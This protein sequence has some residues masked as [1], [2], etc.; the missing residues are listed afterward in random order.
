MHKFLF[1]FILLILVSLSSK[2][3]EG[4]WLPLLVEKYNIGEMQADGFKLSA[5]D[6]YSVNRAS[7]NDGIVQ[8]GGGCTGVLVSEEGLL[9]TNHHCGFKYIQRHSSVEH[10]YLTNGFWARNRNEELSNPALTVTF[11][12]EMRDV[13]KEVLLG[14]EHDMS[15]DE[16]EELIQNNIDTLIS[17]EK[18]DN[19]FKAEIN[20]FF[21]GNQYFMFV[22]QVFTDVRLVGAP[23]SSIGGFGGNIDNWM[24]PR[25]GGDFSI[26]RIYADSAN[27]PKTYS[28]ENVPYKPAYY[29]PVSLKGV[30]EGDFTMVFGYPGSTQQ[31]KTSQHLNM[32]V[33][34]LYPELIHIRD[35]KLEV[36]EKQMNADADI[37]IKYA[38]K[39]A[40]ISN[41]WK[42]WKG[43]IKGLERFN[44]IRKTAAFQSDFQK[45]AA[46]KPV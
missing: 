33:N 35:L 37:R 39:E 19:G 24:W 2:A 29:F 46:N 23:P 32:L 1:S 21:E 40:S 14:V 6:I 3:K 43:E 4:M 38:S 26:F 22:S 44:V 7:M 42:R 36:L 17:K 27:N 45:W 5:E 28:D 25:H 30:Q 9:F 41:S 10:D 34:E 31:Y 18:T 20:E 13:S 8:F 16:R 12:R 15:I 11:L